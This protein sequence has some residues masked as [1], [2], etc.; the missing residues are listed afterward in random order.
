M[1][2][3]IKEVDKVE[4][5]TLQDNYIDLVSRDNTEI[6]LRAMPIKGKEMKNS[7]LAEHGFSSVV[8]VTRGKKTRSILFD[9]GFSA[10]GAAFNAETL[11]VN[12][13]DIEAAALSHGHLD[14]VGGLTE[15]MKSAAK[16][17][18]DLVVHPEVFRD[19]RYL[20]V[21]GDLKIKLPSFTRKTVEEAGMHLRSPLTIRYRGSLKTSG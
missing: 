10:F 2:I 11:G 16:E 13:G 12:L 18:I 7:I 14:H 9:F 8:T 19:P 21:R 15:L 20:M 5:L 6:V 3:T 4:I 17:K 1:G